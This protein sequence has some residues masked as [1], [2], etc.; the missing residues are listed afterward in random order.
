MVLVTPANVTGP[1]PVLMMF[2]RAVLPASAQPDPAVDAKHVGIEGV[3]RYGKAALVT[4][5]FEDRF[6]LGL[7]GSSGKGGATLH[8]R[9]FGEA[10]ENLTGRKG[11][12]ESNMEIQSLQ[13]GNLQN[14]KDDFIPFSFQGNPVS[15]FFIYQCPG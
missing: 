15:R 5:T 13:V 8:R 14:F 12:S 3:S 1:V 2:G 4:L 10:V 9:N 6:A 7:T 11:K